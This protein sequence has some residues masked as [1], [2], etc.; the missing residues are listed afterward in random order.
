M[1][2]HA[3]LLANLEMKRQRFGNHAGSTHVSWIPLYHDLG[4]ILNLLEPLYVGATCVLMTPSG[5]MHRPR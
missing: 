5:F 2:S 3:N 4:L 1:V